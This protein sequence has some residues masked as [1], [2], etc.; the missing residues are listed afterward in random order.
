MA[1]AHPPI[2]A[3]LA[4]PAVLVAGA[5]ALVLV[6]ARALL[7]RT[8][9]A[10]EPESPLA[11]GDLRRVRRWERRLRRTLLLVGTGW[12]LLVGTWVARG[13]LPVGDPRLALG[14]LGVLC[15]LGAVVQFSAHCPR[16]GYNLGFQ[17]RPLGA[18]RCERCGGRYR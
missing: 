16:C 13:A 10:I 14:F 4:L 5:L 17:S 12:L 18:D 2:T 11:P 7:R 1:A 8:P 3:L 9:D 15:L 6:R